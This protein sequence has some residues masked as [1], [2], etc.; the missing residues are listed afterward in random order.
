MARPSPAILARLALVTFAAVC[1]AWL[2]QL[3]YAQKLSTNVLDLIPR[4]ERTPEVGIIRDL[5]NAR[6]SRVVLFALSDAAA[7][8]VAPQAAAQ[9]FRDALAQTPQFE[10][11]LVL[12]DEAGQEDFGRE[13]FERRFELLLPGWL[14]DRQ[15]EFDRTGHPAAEFSPWLAERAATELEAFLGRPEASALADLVLMDPLLLV[16]RLVEHA[17]LTGPTDDSGYALIWAL[18]RESPLAESGQQPVFDA[19]AA[20]TTGMHASHPDV[21]VQWS[22]VNRF[23]AASRSRIESEI[24]LLHL[25]SI[26]AVLLVAAVFVRHIHRIVHFVPVISLSIAGAWVVSTLAFE[27]L[28]ILVFVIGSLLA[29]VAIDYGVYIFLQAPAYPDEP[30][31]GKLRRLLKP[32]LASCLTTVVG[33]SLLLFSDLPMIRQIGLF[34]GSG[35]LCALAVAMLYFAQ[36]RQPFLASRQFG[37]VS[38]ARDR[39][40]A[41]RCVRGLGVVA[42]LIAV[43]GPWHLQ[44]HDDVRELDIPSTELTAN[45]DAVRA[46]FGEDDEGSL[47]LTYGADLGEARQHLE[48]FLAHVEQADPGV[49]VSSLALLLPTAA[50]WQA[51]PERLLALGGFPDDFAAALERHGFSASSFGSFLDEWDDLRVDPPRGDYADLVTRVNMLLEGPLTLLASTDGPYWFLS[52]VE[53]AEELN[54]PAE[55]HTVSVNQLKSLNSLFTRY[56]WSALR[57]SL[58]GLGFI[59]GGVLVIYPLRRAVRIALIPAGSCFVVFGLFGLSGQTLNLFNLLGAFLG[60]CLSH[61]YAIFSAENAQAGQA[62]PVAIRLSALS[63]AA[64]F[65]VLGFSQIPVIHALGLTVSMIVI[66]ALLMVELEPLARRKSS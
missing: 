6:Q 48:S 22:G 20:A 57:L 12:G 16:P 43:L 63:T 51:L 40:R 8:D 49:V 58:I 33:F 37:A 47:Y 28:H 50:D 54:P 66:T 7:P 32:L 11:V 55:W 3:D 4:S 27:R 9:S 38:I 2:L 21:D 61:N 56:R 17:Q 53:S 1:T 60:I 44:W 19:I 41:R 45:D 59:I 18:M 64:A 25:C 10:S 23:A 36:L 5:A 46:L 13:V 30:Y 42:L 35:L 26:A 24:K 15:R 52:I 31:G 29:G 62:P 65:G 39:P 34:V 14:G